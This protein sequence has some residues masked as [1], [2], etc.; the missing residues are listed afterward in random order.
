MRDFTDG[1][2]RLDTLSP[3]ARWIYSAFAG[4]TVLGLVTCVAQYHLI[5]HFDATSTPA[6]LGDRL[7]AHYAAMPDAAPP[8]TAKQLLDITHQH[9][10]SMP[11]YL[12]IAG[13]LML[14]ARV[15]LTVKKW[16]IVVG[17]VSTGLHLVAP[18]FV[19]AGGPAAIWLYPISGA[20]LVASLG[21]MAV[22]PAVQMWMKRPA[23]VPGAPP[24]APRP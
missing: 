14:L 4:Y 1:S 19:R 8:L 10:F 9:L 23:R 18:W 20:A 3:L 7:A 12:L 6:Q 17:I 11:A 22:I 24:S 15:P 21:G 16:F 5:V 13:H 2:G